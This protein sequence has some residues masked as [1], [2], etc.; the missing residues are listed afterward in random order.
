MKSKACPIDPEDF[1]KFLKNIFSS[2]SSSILDYDINMISSIS[3]FSF[4]ELVT[5]LRQ[6]SNLR[7]EDDYDLIAEL[8][9]YGSTK[10]KSLILKNFNDILQSRGVHPD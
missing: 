10:L 9:K 4:D 6:L 1:A 2:S 5:G 7:C 8:I 3:P